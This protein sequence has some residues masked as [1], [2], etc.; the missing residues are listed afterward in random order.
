MAITLFIVIWIP[1]PGPPLFSDFDTLFAFR[2]HPCIGYPSFPIFLEHLVPTNGSDPPP[3]P[4]LPGTE[5]SKISL[6]STSAICLCLIMVGGA[7]PNKI[8]YILI[9]Q[10]GPPKKRT[11]NVDQI[12]QNLVI[13][14]EGNFLGVNWYQNIPIWFSGFWL[15]AIFLN[16]G[17][18]TIMTLLHG[19]GNEQD[20]SC[21]MAPGGRGVCLIACTSSA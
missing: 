18:I 10:G 17:R 11:A 2:A 6:F 8:T 19:T 4:P 1:S 12:W 7:I 5:Q 15:A 16:N 9:I 20:L 13:S 14:W 3:P 21:E